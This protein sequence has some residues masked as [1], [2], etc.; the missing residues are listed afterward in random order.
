MKKIILLAII[1][2]ISNLVL[3]GSAGAQTPGT[4]NFSVTTTEPPGNYNNVNVIALWIT[5]TNN[6]FVKTK[7]RYAGVRIQYLTVWVANS[8]YNTT[9]A[10]TGAT[11]LTH[12][13]LS[14]NWNGT[15][16]GGNVVADQPYR[17]WMQM[18]DANFAGPTNY[19]TFTKD[20]N[21]VSI[22]PSDTGNFTNMTLSW[23]PAI[24]IAER[25]GKKLGF[26]CYPNPLNINSVISF[27]LAKKSD[28]SIT[29]HDIS[30]R[31]VGVLLDRNLAAGSYSYA[32]ADMP[33]LSSKSGV[34]YL[35]INT[36]DAVASQK[37]LI[38]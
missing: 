28:V 4:L 31:S 18:S 32:C 15:D 37:V 24:G 20:S 33:A 2:G 21:T 9:D 13:V 38:K 29:L 30:G 14:F 11:R 34:Y 16:I 27:Q 5:D 23:N 12:G 8:S 1:V 26:H 6:Q 17:V 36:G 25:E 10:T 22:T 35:R 3:P 7:I 19:V